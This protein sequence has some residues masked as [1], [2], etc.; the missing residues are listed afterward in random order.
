M[1]IDPIRQDAIRLHQSRTESGTPKLD[2]S[3]ILNQQ[4]TQNAAGSGPTQTKGLSSPETLAQAVCIGEISQSRPTVSH[5]LIHH[6]DYRQECWQIIHSEQN[7]NRPYRKIEAGTRI[8]ID[9][10]NLRI[11]WND[12][13]SAVVHRAGNRFFPVAEISENVSSMEK[14]DFSNRFVRAIRQNLG[15]TYEEVDCYEL[16]VQGLRQLGY[17]YGGPGGLKEE[18]VNMAVTNQEPV[19]TYF[20]GEGLVASAG[21]ADYMKLYD[22]FSDFSGDAG[23]IMDEIAS[24]IQPGQ[25]LSFS[26]P[27]RGHTGIISAAGGQWTFVNSG[28]LDHDIGESAPRKGV[29]EETLVSEIYN[30]IKLA[31]RKK[32]PLVLTLGHL[33]EDKLEK[34]KVIPWDA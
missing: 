20:S 29:G 16:I 25:I 5:L 3:T 12:P 18:L 13:E 8:F 24:V 23:R 34:Y 21:T 27:S 4:V 30:W 14:E 17:R 6:P 26:T 28:I 22:G 11:F 7:R 32:E 15:L 1:N 2:F 19:N 33:E 31:A 10:T 9:P